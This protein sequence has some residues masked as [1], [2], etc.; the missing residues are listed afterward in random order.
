MTHF[1]YVENI[2]DNGRATHYLTNASHG[3]CSDAKALLSYINKEEIDKEVIFKRV[4]D[5][6]MDNQNIRRL[7]I[8]YNIGRMYF[9]GLGTD[10]DYAKALYYVE[11]SAGQNYTAAQLQLGFLYKNGYGTNQDWTKAIEW[12]T[13]AANQG[14]IAAHYN[15]GYIYFYGGGVEVN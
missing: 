15:L 9:T 7:R 12:Y 13:K 2:N 1:T 4:F 6:H 14:S 8:T 11:I 10:Q 5:W 3:G